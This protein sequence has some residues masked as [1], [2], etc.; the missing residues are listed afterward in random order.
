MKIII[1]IF[2]LSLFSIVAFTQDNASTDIVF[3]KDGS[4][5]RGQITEQNP[6]GNMTIR[7]FNGEELSVSMN[8]VKRIGSDNEDYHFNPD[9]STYRK[10]GVY[11]SFQL[12]GMFTNDNIESGDQNLTFGAGVQYSLGKQFNKHFSLGGGIGLRLYNR[13]FADVFVQARTYLPKEKVSPVLSL[14]GGYGVPIQIVNNNRNAV[15]TKGGASLRPSIGMRIARR[16]HSDIILDAGYQFQYFY[17]KDNW[18][19]GRVNET[20]IWYKRISVKVGWNF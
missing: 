20:T 19:W 6:K 3:L 18:G 9:G 7:L 13:L 15:K 10:Q 14:E 17:Q 12:Q 5:I 16:K 1:N 8:D 2:I 4:T 11:T